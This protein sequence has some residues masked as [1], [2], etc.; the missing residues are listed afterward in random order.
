M[1]K[2]REETIFEEREELMVSPFGGNPTLRVAHFLRPS[3]SIGEPFPMLSSPSSPVIVISTTASD[4]HEPASKLRFKGWQRQP[5]KWE[6]WIRSMR[7]KYQSIWK[8]A[9]IY[10]AIMGSKYYFIKH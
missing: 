8:K 6:A 3:I 2:P 7:P 1:E 9:G 10:E 4:L 5:K